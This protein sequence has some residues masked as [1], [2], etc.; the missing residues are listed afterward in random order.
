M[1]GDIAFGDGY[2]NG[3][4]ASINHPG[5]GDA[6]NPMFDN[7]PGCWLFNMA[8]AGQALTMHHMPATSPPCRPR[9]VSGVAV[10]TGAS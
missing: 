10:R 7:S 2:A 3:G 1:F 9:C 8:A 4:A 6:A 5:V